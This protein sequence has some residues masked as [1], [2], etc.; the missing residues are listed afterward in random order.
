MPKIALPE[1]LTVCLLSDSEGHWANITTWVKRKSLPHGVRYF[2]GLEYLTLG[3]SESHGHI[4][5][6]KEHLQVEGIRNL[7]QLIRTKYP[8][9]DDFFQP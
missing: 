2:E 6:V 3:L 5:T 8:M 4:A 7:I 1:D 9:F